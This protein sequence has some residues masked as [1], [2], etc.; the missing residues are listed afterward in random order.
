MFVKTTISQIEDC[1]RYAESASGTLQRRVP[2]MIVVVYN[3]LPRIFEADL[4]FLLL[5][6][7]RQKEGG[8]GSL[9]KE[10]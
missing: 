10:C 3:R 1:L 8:T 9:T 4:D 6:V 2:Q 7:L 5:F